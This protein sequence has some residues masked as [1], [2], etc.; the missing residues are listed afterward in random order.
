MAGTVPQDKI[1]PSVSLLDPSELVVAAPPWIAAIAGLLIGSFANVCIHRIPIGQ[2]VVTPRSRCPKCSQPIAGWDNVPVLSW[3]LLRGRC[4]RCAASI[5][6]RYPLVEAANAT[7]WGLIAWMHGINARSAF[8]MLFATALLILAL[9]DFDHHILPDA[10]TLPMIGAGLVASLLA[11]PPSVVEA[12]VAAAAMYAAFA[13][14]AMGYKKFRGIEGLGQ[15]DWKMAAMF[16]AFFG[17][18]G[19]LFAV[20]AGALLGSLIGGL[21]IALSRKGAR[22]ELPFGTFLSMGGMAAVLAGPR[23]LAWYRSL[24]GLTP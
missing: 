5:A 21:Y 2:S 22:Y 3:L 7:A 12:L 17:W 9:T 18:Q 11:P 13:A 10:I 24:F 6:G 15:G 16:G 1:A 20:F 23:F 4:R 14:I 19:A 8:E